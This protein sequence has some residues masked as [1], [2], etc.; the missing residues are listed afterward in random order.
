MTQ[1]CFCTEILIIYLSS[2]AN[3]VNI[4]VTYFGDSA[5]CHFQG[6]PPQCNVFGHCGYK[7]SS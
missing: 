3:R 4:K 5:C 2:I 6:S 1:L 7:C